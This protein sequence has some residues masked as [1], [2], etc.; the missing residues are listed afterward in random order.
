[1][2]GEGAA[3]GV[4]AINGHWGPAAFI[5]IKGEGFDLE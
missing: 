5:A 2:E 4:V 1:M 3:T